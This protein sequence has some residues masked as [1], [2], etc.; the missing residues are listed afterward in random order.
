MTYRREDAAALR[1]ERVARI[2]ERIDTESGEFEMVMAT[3]SEASDGHILRIAG[4]SHAETIPLQLDHRRGAADNLGTVRNIRKGKR[5][6]VPALLGVGQ[7]RLSGDGEAAAMRRDLVDAIAA[8][9]LRG[10]SLT[11]SADSEGVRERTALPK[12]HPARV[13]PQEPNLRRRFGLFFEKSEAIE[14]SVVAIPADRAALIG[15]AESAAD[16]A[17]A[18]LWHAFVERLELREAP[19][20]DRFTDALTR[21]LAAAEQRI[22]GAG[23][24]PRDESPG[25]PPLDAV[26]ERLVP[27]LADAPR[28]TRDEMATALDETFRRLTGDIR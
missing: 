19:S 3:E 1:F 13:D 25:L 15:R 8:G 26:L 5:D 7:I 10:T 16:A 17:R 18:G 22:R 21:A 12:G 20:S 28:R 6:G 14:Q 9:H 4:I 23:T 11:W 27:T 24:P 2:D